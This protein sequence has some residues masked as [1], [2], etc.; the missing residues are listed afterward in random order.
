MR[1]ALRHPRNERV[2]QAQQHRAVLHRHDRVAYLAVR[3]GHEARLLDDEV[4]QLCEIDDGRVQHER[5]LGRFRLGGGGGHPPGR[6]PTPLPP[7]EG[8]DTLQDR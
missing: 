3:V 8:S 1:P 4:R 5:E 7:Q 2:P 6:V